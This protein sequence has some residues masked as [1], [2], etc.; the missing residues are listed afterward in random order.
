MFKYK[1]TKRPMMKALKIKKRYGM[2]RRFAHNDVNIGKIAKRAFHQAFTNA[3]RLG[4]PVIQREQNRLV[5][6]YPNGK[7]EIIKTTSMVPV[8]KKSFSL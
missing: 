3:K 6:V 1:I 8:K 7:K 2:K 4:L 5:K